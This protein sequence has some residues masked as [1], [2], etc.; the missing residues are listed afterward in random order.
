MLEWHLEQ[1]FL[2]PVT[3][4]QP[5]L[6]PNMTVSSWTGILTVIHAV[7]M[8][9]WYV[10][11][12]N[13]NIVFLA[14]HFSPQELCTRSLWLVFVTATLLAGS[15]ILTPATTTHTC[16][17]STSVHII[18]HMHTYSCA[19]TSNTDRTDRS[20][21]SDPTP[22][23][24]QHLQPSTTLI[25]YVLKHTCT[26]THTQKCLSCLADVL[27]K[28]STTVFLRVRAWKEQ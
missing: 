3:P 17:Y 12:Q 8:F 2:S 20:W 19:R 18:T 22:C 28:L 26:H 11:N 7:E 13:S 9:I 10:Q 23:P 6:P 25:L 14:G 21:H 5:P 24:C 1:W 27:H 4:P 15:G 16:T